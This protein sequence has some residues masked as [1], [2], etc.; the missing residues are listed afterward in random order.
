MSFLS[1]F[2][3][4]K[5]TVD[6]SQSANQQSSSNTGLSDQV[7]DYWSSI[8]GLYNPS[9]WQNVDPNAYQTDAANRTAGYASGLNPAFAQANQIG[10]TGISNT[11]ISRFMSPYT[12]SVVD[13]TR[14]NFAQENSRQDAQTNANAAKLGALSGTQPLVARAISQ[15]MRQ[16][17]QDATIA[18]LYDKGFTTAL[19]AANQSTG[20]QLQGLNSANAIAGQQSG[21][22]QTGF[23]QGTQLWNQ[24]WQNSGGQAQQAAQGAQVLASLSPQSG[25]SSTGSSTGTGTN[26]TT[27]TPSPFSIASNIAGMA[28]SA[29]AFSDARIKENIKP[30]GETYDGQQIYKYNIKGSP[31]TEIGLMAQE[32]EERDPDAVGSIAGIKTVNYDRATKG[33]EKDEPGM[34]AGGAVGVKPRESDPHHRLTTAFDAVR[35]MLERARGGSVLPKFDAG[36]SVGPSYNPGWNTTV[37]P[38]QSGSSFDVKK[39]GEG[40]SAMG[41]PNGQSGGGGDDGSG[42]LRSAQQDLSSFMSRNS[43]RPG[44]AEGGEVDEYGGGDGDI[45]DGPVRGVMKGYVPESSQNFTN[46]A[47]RVESATP[48][49]DPEFDRRIRALV[50]AGNGEGKPVNFESVYRSPHDQARAINSVSQKVNGRPA[51]IIDYARGIPGYAAPI[52]GSMHQKGLAADLNGEGVTWARENAADYGIRFPKSLSR[53]DPNHAEIDPNFMGPVQDPRDRAATA[54]AT[55]SAP[56]RAAEIP[57][58]MTGSV[59]SASEGAQSGLAPSATPA[60]ASFA[61]SAAPAEK[62]WLQ[63]NLPG[64]TEGVFNGERMTPGQRLG[65]ALMSVRGPMFEGPANGIARSIMEMDGS[66]Q[67]DDQIKNQVDQ[68]GRT[69]GLKDRELA[70]SEAKS[71]AEIALL[72]AQAKA[73]RAAQENGKFVPYDPSKGVLNARTGV[74]TPPLR[75][76]SDTQKIFD[77]KY[78]EKAPD[79]LEKSG[80]AYGDANGMVSSVKEL[81]AIAP[82]AET[83]FGQ[84]QVL[85]LRKMG[86]RFG[87]DV[88]DKVAPTELFRA[89]SQNFVLQAAQK[90]KPLSNS[91]VAFVQKGLATIESDPSTLKTLLPGM[92]A[93]AERQALVE[94]KRMEYLSRGKP[95]PMEQILRDVD[96]KIPS[97][98]IEQ[99][100]VKS[101]PATVTQGAASLGRPAPDATGQAETT[102]QKLLEMPDGA[103]VMFNGKPKIKQGDKLIDAPADRYSKGFFSGYMDDNYKPIPS[104]P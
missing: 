56:I 46:P 6:T 99:F 15:S 3:S 74:V 81:A 5:K 47:N 61:T 23:G 29:G 69:M 24:D 8:S 92:Q 71:P 7:K 78:A 67:K 87:L 30:I 66:R 49:L 102:R 43:I 58:R 37:T 13:A 68:F 16:P 103:L 40:L 95:P 44:Y 27:A 38:A 65:T 73:Q 57:P 86:A 32:V 25:V 80:A 1:N 36:G 21:I 26:T 76:G 63:R 18:G 85:A 52:G 104:F 42:A 93:I 50:T 53:T 17:G 20:L 75:D 39:F 34:A 35:G 28:I 33:A 45:P 54:A 90:L 72:E 70:L 83:G 97:P 55:A 91:D 82:F 64:L 31:K 96:A 51:S 2:F 48:K 94:Q 9:S 77:E 62:S 11:D 10:G 12:Q 4:D 84:E 41:K 88:S 60:V 19:G 79:L 98:I 89:L 100:G 22:N 59:S 14:A 101:T